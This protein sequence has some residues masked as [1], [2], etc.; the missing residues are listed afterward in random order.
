MFKLAF[1][2]SRVGNTPAFSFHTSNPE[3]VLTYL[4]QNEP[5]LCGYVVDKILRH[6]NQSISLYD[7]A[8]NKVLADRDVAGLLAQARAHSNAKCLTAEEFA[9]EWAAGLSEL[10]AGVVPEAGIE[11]AKAVLALSVKKGG[12]DQLTES[13]SR[14]IIDRF[15]DCAESHEVLAT[16]VCNAKSRIAEIEKMTAIADTF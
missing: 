16:A 14:R 4:A 10:V 8:A 3:V 6:V 2:K 5:E 1:Q 13:V 7:C 15:A 12:R 11:A 9:H